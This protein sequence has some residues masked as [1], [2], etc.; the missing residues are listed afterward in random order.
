MRDLSGYMCVTLII[1]AC[2]VLCVLIAV[3]VFP[4]IESWIAPVR[5]WVMGVMR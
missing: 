3:Y 1:A 5:N 4:I 2:L